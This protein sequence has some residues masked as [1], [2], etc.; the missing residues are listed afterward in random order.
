M[1][2]PSAR[3]CTFQSRDLRRCPDSL[4]HSLTIVSHLSRYYIDT[5]DEGLDVSAFAIS[6]GVNGGTVYRTLVSVTGTATGPEI[7]MAFENDTGYE[8]KIGQ[9]F[10]TSTTSRVVTTNGALGDAVATCGLL[11]LTDP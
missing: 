2:I 9:V 4:T 8:Q 3:A 7:L 11:G 10:K 1:A 5:S 6:V